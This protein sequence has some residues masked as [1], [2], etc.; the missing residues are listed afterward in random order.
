M[1]IYK[2]ECR[3]CK[4]FHHTRTKNICTN[5]IIDPWNIEPFSFCAG[6]FEPKELPPML[7]IW[8]TDE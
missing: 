1:K 5:D 2:E 6:G 7:L 4:Y 3:F 8:E